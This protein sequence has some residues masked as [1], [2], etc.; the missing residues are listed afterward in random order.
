MAIVGLVGWFW[1]LNTEYEY[2]RTL[3]RHENLAA[4]RVYPLNVHGIV[5]WQTRAEDS[6][7]K[8]RE[9]SF[10]GVVLIAILVWQI[11]N[12]EKFPWVN[13]RRALF[14]NDAPVL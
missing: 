9:Y 10:G 11:S 12:N 8:Q 6:R 2:Q 14:G 13:V 3:P 1:A 5:V 4:G 7:R